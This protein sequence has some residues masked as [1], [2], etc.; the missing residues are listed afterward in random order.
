M[1]FE[2][3]TTRTDAAKPAAPPRHHPLL[4]LFDSDEGGS[5]PNSF[6]IRPA[7]PPQPV[8][9]SHGLGFS[10]PAE[11]IRPSVT[12][13]TFDDDSDEDSPPPTARSMQSPTTLRAPQRQPSLPTPS[14]LPP[15]PKLNASPRL[16]HRSP[17][18]PSPHITSG[19]FVTPTD[20]TFPDIP[21]PPAL[22]PLNTSPS[23]QLTREGGI[24]KL[25]I[26]PT[27]RSR[28]N[29]LQSQMGPPTLNGS[30]P[31]SRPGSSRG[32]TT[33]E[34]TLAPLSTKTHAR[35]VRLPLLRLE[36]AGECRPHRSL[37]HRATSRDSLRRRH[38]ASQVQFGLA[39]LR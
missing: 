23:R 31:A 3:L 12:I 28:A 10:V 27:Y 25:V 34:T 4:R 21:P 8:A 9:S 24:D 16:G 2:L 5:Q 35:K 33:A 14:S 29:T 26:S 30:P 36:I 20:S 11:T 37:R 32:K 38:R 18:P 17:T 39:V 19:G 22:P 1:F 15:S 7:A 13:P 6:A